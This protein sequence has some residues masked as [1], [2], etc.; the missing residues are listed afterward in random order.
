MVSETAD[1]IDR[2]FRRILLNSL[3][4]PENGYSRSTLLFPSPHL[5]PVIGV[6]LR[7]IGAIVQPESPVSR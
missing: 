6:S 1:P 3:V 7:V 4:A 5:N 2:I